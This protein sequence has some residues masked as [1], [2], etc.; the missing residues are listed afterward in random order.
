VSIRI[1]IADDHSIVRKGIKT[2]LSEHTEFLV[3]GEAATT[4]EA[5]HLVETA[6]PDVL[7]LDVQMPGI[8]AVE[9]IQKVK[10]QE[11]RT[12]VIILSAFKEQAIVLGIMKAG[13]DGYLL[14]DEDTFSIPQAIHKVMKG[15]PCVSQ[16]ITEV[17]IKQVREPVKN[18]SLSAFTE[19]EKQVLKHIAD[20]RS[21][22]E[23]AQETG[24]AM[25]TVEAHVS[26]IYEKL[27]ITSRTKVAFWA[28]ENG[29][30][31]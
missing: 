14:K 27:G 5:L 22:K 9:L 24:M 18:T 31:D 3:V 11:E 20:G 13:A 29:L 8:K 15:L 2:E 6:R 30:I 17:L 25:R 10:K 19:R 7:L 26:R 12:K 21:N 28:K 1:V 16:S 4:D 23:I